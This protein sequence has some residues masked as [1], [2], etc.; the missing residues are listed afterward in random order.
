MNIYK[1]TI[2]YKGTHYLGFQIQAQGSTIQG[3]INKALKILSK[4]EE[5]KSIGSGRTDAG[6]HAIA[7]VMRVEIPVFIPAESLCKAMNSNLPNDIR[8]VS[9][10]VC[11]DQF[12][13]IYSAKS[14]EYNYV[15]TTNE[16]ITSFAHDL[17]THF[18][19][20]LDIELM[21]KGCDIFLGEHDFINYQCTGTEVEST[22]RN[23]YSCEL[24]H[25]VSEGHWA[26]VASD[27][28]VL[29]ITGNGFLK[30]MVRLIMGAL[31]SLG[32]GKISLEDLE[33]SLKTPLKNRLGATAPSQGLYLKRV[34][35]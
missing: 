26:S 23:I 22:V 20:D 29:K 19:Y 12:H 8:V 11:N 13:P 30:Q 5:I 7:Q 6:V 3:E 1:I 9:A 34:D 15:F 21:K 24:I 33:K 10:E 35:Y 4:S 17:I 27:Y 32:K 25:Y 14:K 28:F 2:Q 31:L 16:K 18:P